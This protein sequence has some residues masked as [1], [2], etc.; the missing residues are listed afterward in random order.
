MAQVRVNG[1]FVLE[2]STK[3]KHT[4]T[5]TKMSTSTQAEG[6]GSSDLLQVVKRARTAA[7]IL[8][9]APSS[10]K[11]AALANI[12]ARLRDARAAV[13]AA[14]E[15]DVEEAER[16]AKEKESREGKPDK[17]LRAL[18]KRLRLPEKKVSSLLTGLSEVEASDD[19][20]GIVTRAVALDDRAGQGPLD[21]YR[22]TCPIGVLCV[23]FEARPDAA[24]QIASLAIKSGNALLLKG[25]REARR[26]NAALVELVRAALGDAGLPRD[27]VQL[28][29]TREQVAA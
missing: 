12:G 4:T 15:E 23:I 11:N 9:A 25:G 27:C 26:T 10:T 6:E 24:V 20:V 22:V 18:L 2:S 28:V 7:R 1:L 3:D 14:N 19:P 21:L 5:P 29:E 13:V 8:A 17:S 16:E